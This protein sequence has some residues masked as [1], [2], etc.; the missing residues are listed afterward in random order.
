MAPPKIP[1]HGLL[2]G[3]SVEAEG[4]LNYHQQMA[5]F[6]SQ[7]GRTLAIDRSFSRWDDAQPS[8]LVADDL[9]D[10]RVPFLSIS[11]LKRDGSK[12]PWAS[13]AAGAYDA[14]IRTQADALRG[15]ARPMN[16]G[17]RARGR[18]PD[19]IRNGVRLPGRLPALRIDLPG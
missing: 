3:A 11:G 9:T 8:A 16:P 15:T 5:A 6:E 10:G 4:A 17:V 2:F 7:L 19:W 1:T 14:D 13:I 18:H 12:L